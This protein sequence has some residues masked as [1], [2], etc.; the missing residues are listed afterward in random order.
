MK[1]LLPTG[2]GDSLWALTKA[3]GISARLGD[4]TV[5]VALTCSDDSP[6]STRS[7]EFV[8]RFP[9]VASVRMLRTGAILKPGP[10]TD[11]RGRYRYIDDGDTSFAPGWFPLVPNAPL[12]RGE[13]LETWFP[14]DE[15]DWTIMKKWT[16][17]AAETELAANLT[18]FAGRYAIIYPGPLAGNTT[19]GHNRGPMWTPQQWVAL[20]QTIRGMNLT[21][22]AIGA[23]YDWD[24]YRHHIAHALKTVDPS[25][26]LVV[27]LIGQTPSIGQTVALIRGSAFGVYYQSGLGCISAFEGIPTAMFWR[28]DG[29]S[30]HPKHKL[31]FDERMASAWVPPDSLAKYL[32]CI[33]GRAT[34]D[35]IAAWAAERSKP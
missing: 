1:F 10:H 30:I 32:P 17:T 19:E 16:N 6:V 9:F 2:L 7:L 23:A 28:P 31:C 24:Y 14:D 33:Y 34:P 18:K 25:M 22:V 35:T 27:S 13:R 29:N 8:R 12:E 21:P 11:T 20:A 26:K 5:D 3:R 4:G 15:I